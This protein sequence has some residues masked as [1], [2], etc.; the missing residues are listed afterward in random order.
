MRFRMPVPIHGWRAFAGEVGIIVLG[1]LLAL[2][3]QQLAETINWNEQVAAE[4]QALLQE[5][6][7][8]LGGAVLRREQQACVDRRLAEILAIL[9]QHHAGQPVRL[10]SPVARPAR[11]TAT[12]GSWQIALSGQ[13]L[14]HMGDH[15]KLMF[16][17]AFGKFDA[18]DQATKV[19]AE[20]WGRL[21]LLDH[22]DLMNEADWSTVRL[23]YTEA[24]DINNRLKLL[25]PWLVSD[26]DRNFP[27]LSHY[28]SADN[29]GVFTAMSQGVCHPL[30]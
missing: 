6:S 12:R 22:P 29:L 2:G 18:W 17:D 23:A 28:R 16:S 20:A 19:E 7:D 5:A 10:I 1:V 4:R 27:A 25:A 30:I 3:A 14:S 13:S 11:K 8:S 9:R 26:V 15:E 24:A 21:M